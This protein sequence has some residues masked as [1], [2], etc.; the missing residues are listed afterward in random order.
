MN[1]LTARE[2]GE[3]AASACEAKAETVVS[4]FSARAASFIVQHLH[5]N[6]GTSGEK[7]VDACKQN[8]IVPH[9][10]RAFGAVFLRLARVG[11]IIK[12]GYVART[13]GHGAPG[14]TVWSL[15]Q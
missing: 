15:I 4:D 9:N 6:G 1:L 14:G 12:A 10:D 13:K 5:E 3:Q 7:L 8:G 2:I 11:K